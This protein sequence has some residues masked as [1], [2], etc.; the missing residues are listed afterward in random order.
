[1]PSEAIKKLTHSGKVR[2]MTEEKKKRLVAAGT[3]AV[4]L[5]V[6]IL[7][8]VL[9]YQLVEIALLSDRKQSLKEEM[10]VLQEETERAE[11]TLDYYKSYSGLLDKAYEYGFVFD[12]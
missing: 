9:V 10:Q 7:L 12:K 4:I 3:V 1:M 2:K 8:A 11:T 5:L 6:V